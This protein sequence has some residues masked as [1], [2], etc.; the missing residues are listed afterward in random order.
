MIRNTLGLFLILAINLPLMALSVL[1]DREIVLEKKLADLRAAFTDIEKDSLNTDFKIYL[2]ETLVQ[3]GSFE[4]RFDKL[5]SIGKITSPDLFF[6]IYTWNVVMDDQSNK[7]FAFIQSKNEKKNNYYITELIDR[8]DIL[9]RRP[10]GILNPSSWYGALYY[11]IIPVKKGNKT[12]YTVFGLDKNGQYSNVKV[13]DVLTFNANHQIKIGSPIFKVKNEISKRLFFEYSAETSMV[14]KYEADRERIVMDHLAP[15]SPNMTGMYE[16]YVPDLS[17]DALVLV[18]DKWVYKE[19]VVAINGKASAKINVKTLDSATGEV[20]E[21]KIKNKWENPSEGGTSS[22]IHKSAM[23]EEQ[24]QVAPKK[25]KVKTKK[26]NVPLIK[27]SKK[28]TNITKG[29]AYK[30]FK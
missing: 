24:I 5:T 22:N 8:S 4:Y 21:K 3:E 23:P 12:L 13:I 14:L 30:K 1:E 10:D 15:E 25:G 17:Y 28:N 20:V 6:R 18:D 16:Y 9:P 2:A 7:Y 11:H 19:D 27:E 26:Q 29:R